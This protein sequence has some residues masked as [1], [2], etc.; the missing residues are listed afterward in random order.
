MPRISLCTSP[1]DMRKSF[2]GLIGVVRTKLGDDPQTGQQET[3]DQQKKTLDQ[4][5]AEV[6]KRN[7]TIEQ[8]LEMI[9]GKKSGK[10]SKEKANDESKDKPSSDETSKNTESQDGRKKREKNDGA[11]RMDEDIFTK[12]AR[13]IRMRNIVDH[14][15]FPVRRRTSCKETHAGRTIDDASTGIAAG[16]GSDIRLVS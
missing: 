7:V 1:V 11:G 5:V 2:N 15:R 12:P 4:L 9:F 14:D 6:S 10:Q 16:V 8:L 13:F 3:L